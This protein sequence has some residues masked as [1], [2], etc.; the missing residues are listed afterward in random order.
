[1]LQA[2]ETVSITALA[3][4]S[5]TGTLTSPLQS[6]QNPPAEAVA[7]LAVVGDGEGGGECFDTG[8]ATAR[9]GDPNSFNG[10][11]ALGPIVSVAP[12]AADT[13]EPA[14]A[15]VLGAAILGLASFRRRRTPA[16]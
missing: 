7:A 3:S 15:A 8:S 1:V 11:L 13:P 4:S 12:A 14:S 5:A 9:I 2:N 16:S 10:V 6:C